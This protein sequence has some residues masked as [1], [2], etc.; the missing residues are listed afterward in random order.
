MN[1]PFQGVRVDKKL[2]IGAVVVLVALALLY[3]FVLSAPT[4]KSAL[5]S[6]GFRENDFQGSGPV[7]FDGTSFQR[8]TSRE[9]LTVLRASLVDIQNS[10]IASS[11]EKAK[12]ELLVSSINH[13]LKQDAFFSE[14]ESMG[15]SITAQNPWEN[16]DKLPGLYEFR[17]KQNGLY[18]DAIDLSLKDSQISFDSGLGESFLE[19]D[20]EQE[21]T[22]LENLD[23][24]ISIMEN[25]CPQGSVA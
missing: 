25:Y 10:L 8:S 16:C 1:L 5:E 9:S 24:I 19:I 2:V 4:A 15:S 14:I 13:E 3:I 21:K 20:L 23:Y 6:N 22:I 17:E 18:A 11:Q 7:Y 12:A